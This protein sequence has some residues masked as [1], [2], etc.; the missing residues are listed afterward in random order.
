MRRGT[1]GPI[2]WGPQKGRRSA[3]K[4]RLLIGA[5]IAIFAIV[6]FLGRRQ[7]NQYTGEKQFVALVPQQEIALGLQAAPQMMQQHGGLDPDPRRQELID[8]I[9]ARLI[10]RTDVNETPWQ[11]EFHLLADPRTVN[12]FA[13]P[14]GQIFMTDALFSQLETEGQIAGVLGHE[15]GHVVAR[16]S[17]Q[18]MAKQSLTQGLIGAVGVASE[19]ASQAQMAEMVGAMVNMKYGRGDELESDTLGVIIMAE[20]GYDPR[21]MIKVMDVLEGAGGGSRKAEFFS[22]HPSPENRRG[23]IRA[24][25]DKVF[26]NGVPDGLTP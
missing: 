9:G 12:A 18:R 25:I 22:T 19:S 2:S 15:I 23:E 8:A 5:G 14:G 24:A 10:Q 6:S 20:A 7:I 21:A 17:A 3:A 13:L 11:F 1:R 26:P 4:L 16:H